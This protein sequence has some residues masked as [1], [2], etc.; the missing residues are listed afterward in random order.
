MLAALKSDDLDYVDYVP[1]TVAGTLGK[2]GDIQVVKGQGSEVR[3]FGFNSN[4]KKKKNRELLDPKLRDALSHAFDRKQ[5]VDVVFRGHAEPR[6]TLLTPISA[7]YMNTDLAAREVR[8]RARQQHARQAR[9]QARLGRHPPHAGRQLAPDVLRR[10][11][12]RPASPASTASS[13]SC[14]TRSR[15]I[16]V[17]LTQRAYDGDDGVRRDHEAEEPVPRLRPDD[18]GLGRLRRSRLRALGA[19]AATSTAAGATP[20][21]CNPAYDKL[22]QQQGVTLDPAKRKAIVWKMQ[23]ILYRDKPYVQLVQ[24]QLIYGF[25]KGWTGIAPPYLNGLGKLPWI[26]LAKS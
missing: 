18:V 16:G 17:K 1:Q 22:Y 11:H 2:S 9:L 5:I 4:P 3:D 25:R 7:P 15:K 21:Y 24:L 19:S 23:E 13:R 20:A 12:A 14:A 10:D 6:A 26:D 8:P